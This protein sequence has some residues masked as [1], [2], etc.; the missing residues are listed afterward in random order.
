M[1]TAAAI[2]GGS[3]IGAGAS[4]YGAKKQ[5]KAT[6][7]AIAAQNELVGPFAEFGQQ[8]LAPLSQFVDNGA[9][10][11]DT[12]AFKDITNSAK[13]GGQYLSGNRATAL[14]DYYATN[15]RPQRFNELFSTATLGANAAAGQATNLGNLYQSQGATQAGGIL[16]AANAANSGINSLAFLNMLNNNGS[17]VQSG[18]NNLLG[19]SGNF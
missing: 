1:P 5:S 3:L 7:K 18:V 13:A 9:N 17:G 2:I 8:R 19:Q 10:F 11:S 12:Q 6:D 14:T 15:F 16:G 4:I